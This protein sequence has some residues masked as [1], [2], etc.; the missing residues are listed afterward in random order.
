MS[1]QDKAR[2][3]RVK[4]AEYDDWAKRESRASNL[5]LKAGKV[6]EAGHHAAQAAK[7]AR[8]ARL[9]RSAAQDFERLA[10]ERQPLTVAP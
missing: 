6:M 9:Q 7:C 3:A 1:Y 8:Y 2:A 4:A 10:N 5:A